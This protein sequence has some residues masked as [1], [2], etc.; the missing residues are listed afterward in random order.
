[1]RRIPLKLLV[2]PIFL[3]LLFGIAFAATD[4]TEIGLQVTRVDYVILT[5]TAV[6]ASRYFSVDDIKPAGRRGPGP[7]V[8]L[9]TLGLESNM[10]GNCTL[11]FSTQNNF[12]LRHI[13]SNKRLTRYRLEYQGTRI[14]ANK[15]QII[16]P[17]CNVA[18]SPLDFTAVGRFRRRVEA[19]IYRDIV[20]IVVTTE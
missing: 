7:T 2:A 15:P 9:V 8:T 10:S 19:G 14:K 18:N 11:D 4:S 17:S 16:L 20:T 3:S 5:G 6:G 12:R 1:M 13:V